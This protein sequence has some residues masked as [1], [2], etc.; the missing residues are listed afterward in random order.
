ML[1]FVSDLDGIHLNRID[2][3]EWSDAEIT[4]SKALQTVIATTAE[5]LQAP[6]KG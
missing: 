5:L 2:M 1:E 6:V 4:T 3:I